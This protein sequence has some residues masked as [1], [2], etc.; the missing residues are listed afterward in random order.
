MTELHTTSEDDLMLMGTVVT[1]FED[2]SRNEVKKQLP[3]CSLC[4]NFFSQQQKLQG[5]ILFKT[6]RNVETKNKLMQLWSLE[7]LYVVCGSYT[8]P[9]LSTTSN[10]EVTD[11]IKAH[12]IELVTNAVRSVDWNLSFSAWRELYCTF[13]DIQQTP[14]VIKWRVTV[15]RAGVH[16][17]KTEE[18]TIA[19]VN[20][21]NLEIPGNTFDVSLK[22]YQ[23]EIFIYIFFDTVFVCLTACD[24]SLCLRRIQ[25]RQDILNGTSLRPSIA[26]NMASMAQIQPGEVVLDLCCGT[27]TLPVVISQLCS[28][29]IVLGVDL[30]LDQLQRSMKNFEAS[31][32][33]TLN[34]P[35]VLLSDFGALP[36]K[37]NSVDVIISNLPFGK[38]IGTHSQ[39]KKIYPAL[40][41]EVARVLTQTGRVIFLTTETRLISQCV[42]NNKQFLWLRDRTSV[43]VGGLDAWVHVICKKSQ[44][45][46]EKWRIGGERIKRVTEI[47]EKLRREEDLNRLKQES[48][49]SDNDINSTE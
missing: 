5:R 16:Y 38:Q 9:G 21:I 24:D 40:F 22:D 49:S 23:L 20:S 15:R 3:N 37:S 42:K 10:N 12:N 43:C 36:F 7:K 8:I 4:E 1:G 27:G 11:K 29:N 25:Q 44:R 41:S 45:S 6:P 33:S 35:D 47:R 17:F 2:S 13:N 39:N 19:C 46:L 28:S 34:P 18:I 48:N 32:V 14:D 26:Y 30:D 31:N